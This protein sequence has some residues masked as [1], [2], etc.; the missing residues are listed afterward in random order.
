MADIFLS[1]STENRRKIAILVSLFEQYGWSVWWDRDIE[2][3]HEWEQSIVQELASARCVIVAWSRSS[4][5]SEWV[6]CEARIGRERGVLFPILLEPVQPP[7]EFGQIQTARL[8]AWTGT[9]DSEEFQKLLRH[10]SQLLGTSHA[11][12]GQRRL[13]QVLEEITRIDAAHSA[14]E[15]CAALI[16]STKQRNE[17]SMERVRLAYEG[18]ARVLVPISDEDLHDL[19]ERFLGEFAA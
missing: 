13:D 2:T 3:G 16:A 7:S 5:Q 4:L 15:Y 18:L 1:Y 19:L 10:L 9:Q 17:E 14:L 11:D 6:Q 8:T 12:I